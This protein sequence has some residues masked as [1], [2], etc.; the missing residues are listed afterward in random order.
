MADKVG[1]T[2]GH[3]PTDAQRQY[4]RAE[5]PEVFSRWHDPEKV[6]ERDV[7]RARWLL[8]L[9]DAKCL[10]GTPFVLLSQLVDFV[11]VGGG[12]GV[13]AP[14]GTEYAIYMSSPEEER[15]ATRQRFSTVLATFAVP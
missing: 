8:S 9:L 4:A 12:P 15:T 14:D 11:R 3:T 13:I 1:K 10:P 2:S 6:T 5:L 7:E